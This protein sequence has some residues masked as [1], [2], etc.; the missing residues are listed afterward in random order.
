MDFEEI[1]KIISFKKYHF[2]SDEIWDQINESTKNLLTTSLRVLTYPKKQIVFQENGVPTGVYFIKKGRVKKYKKGPEGKE[3]IFYIASEGEILGY[4]ALLCSEFYSDTTETLET[5]EIGFIPKDVF[6]EI[7]NTHHDLK[8]QLVQI[9]G[10]EYGVLVNHITMMGQYNVKER[11][12]IIL[13]LLKDKYKD[14]PNIPADINVSRED[15]ANFV[16]TARENLIR[17]L[18][19]FKVSK[20]IATEGRNIRILNARELVQISKI[21]LI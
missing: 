15:L 7:Y 17:L 3:Q 20:L 5:C 1:K 4:H 9:M 6:L 14:A 18:N 10:H 12:A 11:L 16:G 21:A 8:D 19:E 2:G 13:L